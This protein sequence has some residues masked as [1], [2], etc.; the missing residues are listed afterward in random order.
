MKFLLISFLLFMPMTQL[1]AVE[2][3][4]DA[5]Q[6]RGDNI[7][8]AKMYWLNGDVRFEYTEDGVSMAQIFDYKNNKI[9]WLD[10]D[11]KY[12]L[13]RS[14]S[15][16]DSVF[17]ENIKNKKNSDPCKQFSDAEC[18][19]LKKTEVNGRA[20]EKWLITLEN[21]FH[22]FQWLDIKYK[23]IL[24]Q[25]HS[26]GS[27]LDVKIEDDLKI[28]DRNVR[29]LTMIAYNSTGKTQKGAQ[30]LDNKL[31]I[32]V[33]Q[34]YQANVVDELKNIKIGKVSKKL[35]SVPSNYTLYKSSTNDK[36]IG[37]T[38]V[39]KVANKN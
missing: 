3:T 11:N 4:A 23:N 22:V 25:E 39:V 14:L 24:K 21:D 17:T 34:E 29:K 16:A 30:W 37:D 12:Y 6:I 13:E 19:F 5:V 36:K 8:Y 9:I 2:F 33:K 28:N 27:G 32:V 20:A 1:N 7:S 10:N 15:E 18:I 26:D 31:D 35:F 38:A